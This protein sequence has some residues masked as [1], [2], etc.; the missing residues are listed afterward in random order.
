MPAQS[1]VK[2]NTAFFKEWMIDTFSGTETDSL[3]QRMINATR[4]VQPVKNDQ[5]HITQKRMDGCKMSLK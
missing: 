5:F 3:F 4:V 1:P 2:M